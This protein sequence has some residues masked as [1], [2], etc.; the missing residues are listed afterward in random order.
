MGHRLRSEGSR[1]YYGSLCEVTAQWNVRE[2]SWQ[3]L[4]IHFAVV[5]KNRS[6]SDAFKGSV[7][8]LRVPP[9]CSARA[10]WRRP[11]KCPCR[12]PT[13]CTARSCQDSKIQ[14]FSAV[15]A[16]GIWV[17]HWNW[18][19]AQRTASKW[20]TEERNQMGVLTQLFVSLHGGRNKRRNEILMK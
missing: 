9:G 20:W 12:D 18:T 15:S 6:H 10:H 14:R 19:G 1:G 8:P 7:S 13:F 3:H 11:S 17:V 5:T 16:V 2:S 4:N